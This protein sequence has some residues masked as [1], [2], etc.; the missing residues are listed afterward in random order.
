MVEV[1]LVTLDEPCSACIII[2]NLIKEMFKELAHQM[3]EVT[4]TI[5]EMHH[6]NELKGIKGI[7]VEKMPIILIQDEQISAGSL[8]NKRYLKQLIEEESR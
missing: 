2:T 5:I 4:F 8:P 7:E 3:P 6:I 1:K